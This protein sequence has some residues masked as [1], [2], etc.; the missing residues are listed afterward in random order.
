MELLRPKLIRKLNQAV[1]QPV[2]VIT[3]PAGSGKSVLI[4]QW[5][6][7]YEGPFARVT[8]SRGDDWQ[9]AAGRI[10]DALP[11]RARA[12]LVI[13]AADAPTDEEVAD[14]LAVL[15]DRAPVS[16]HL[17]LVTRSRAVPA[18]GAL[19]GRTDVA[20]LNASHLA[21]TRS[22]A[23]QLIRTAAGVRISDEGL[24]HL[25]RA[26]EGWTTGVR[27]AAIGL[28][29]APDPDA[30]AEAFHG[31]ERHVASFF[32]DE[33]FTDHPHE[34]RG[35]L[36]ATSVLDSMTGA[37]CDALTGGVEGAAMLRRLEHAGVFVRRVPGSRRSFTYHNL[38]RQ[39]LRRQLRHG[40]FGDE[41]TLLV[42]AGTWHAD[43]DDPEAAAR[44]LVE[45]EAWEDLADLADRYG[46]RMYESG[47][48]GEVL[49]W[50]E[51]IPV[52]HARHSGVAVRR[53]YLHTML[54]ESPQASQIVHDLEIRHLSAGDKVAA[55]ALRALWTFFDAEPASTIAAAERA[56]RALEAT[57]VTEIPDIFGMTSPTSLA[58]MAAS[59]RARALWYLGQIAEA[60]RVLSASIG[61][62]GVYTPWFVRALSSLAVLEAWA[63]NL[64]TSEAHATRALVIAGNAGLLEH[65]SALDARLALASVLRQRG[66]QRGAADALEHVGAIA[67]RTR[68]PFQTA[69]LAVERGRWHLAA[70]T[71]RE[72]LAAL[73]RYRATVEQPAPPL[74]E[75]SLCAA[76]AALHLSADDI[77]SAA[78]IVESAADAPFCA[79]LAA[80]TVHLSVARRDF[81]AA[82]AALESWV[83][84]DA[85]PGHRRQRDLWASV[86]EYEAGDRRRALAAVSVTVTA[87]AGEAD[88]R[89][90]LDGGRPVERLVRALFHS[91]PSPFV[92]RVMRSADVAG[93]SLDT[94]VVGLSKREMEVARYLPTPLS[95]AEIAQQLYISLNTLKTHLRAIYTKLGATNRREAIRRAEELGIA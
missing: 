66:D 91:E 23:R 47:G 20:F 14:E 74:I 81:A 39:F 61:Q 18:L 8:L 15:V 5:A 56:L 79:D 70:R 48:A 40:E 24:E 35:F 28:R 54:G 88:I 33:V 52:T 25:I 41:T 94:S 29:E 2:T 27:V 46:Q 68:R 49:H 92:E 30:Y 64:R 77:D 75:A 59:S 65:P 10:S 36:V 53:A 67:A 11:S 51:A 26:T 57:D 58:V 17:V 85:Q 86:V 60:R 50:L 78:G 19:H 84:D 37:L 71:P 93:E 82:G 32:F 90:F 87:A 55:D 34:V 13:D 43:R 9:R 6:A 42:R 22:E 72:G 76:E 3:A 12:V 69:M 1:V 21:F 7:Q 80:A 63:G 44:Y 4:D 16:L 38:F 31:D 95:S 89:L 45:A 83:A 73:A 62:E